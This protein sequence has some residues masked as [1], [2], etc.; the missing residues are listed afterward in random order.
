MLKL[1]D[2]VVTTKKDKTPVPYKAEYVEPFPSDRITV[3]LAGEDAAL[4]TTLQSSDIVKF[5]LSGVFIAEFRLSSQK[6]GMKIQ[7]NRIEYIEGDKVTIFTNEGEPIVAL[8]VN[9]DFKVGEKIYDFFEVY[10]SA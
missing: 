3:R 7:G 10:Q 4:A 9:N 1:F 2:V 5:D 8:L 6:H